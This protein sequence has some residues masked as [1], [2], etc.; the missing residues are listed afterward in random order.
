MLM[1]VPT[2]LFQ[3][4]ESQNDVATTYSLFVKYFY[5]LFASLTCPF[6]GVNNNTGTI[7]RYGTGNFFK[8]SICFLCFFN[9]PVLEMFYY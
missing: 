9:V 6:P 5:P 2:V 8:Y 3:F 4:C 1:N 7:C